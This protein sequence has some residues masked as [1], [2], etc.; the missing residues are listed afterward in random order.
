MRAHKL[1]ASLKGFLST[2]FEEE[3]GCLTR[4][5][6]T[7]MLLLRSSLCLRFFNTARKQHSCQSLIGNLLKELASVG[8]GLPPLLIL[9]EA[10]TG[11]RFSGH[12]P[13]TLDSYKF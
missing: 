13:A 7:C 10:A 9:L 4:L 2:M 1:K 6:V 12:G 3:F 5:S 8:G 11:R